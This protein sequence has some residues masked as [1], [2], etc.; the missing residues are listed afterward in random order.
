MYYFTCA[1]SFFFC[2][3]FFFSNVRNLQINTVAALTCFIHGCFYLQS[4]RC[5]GRATKKIPPWF[6]GQGPAASMLVGGGQ[7][8]TRR[9]EG[10][11]SKLEHFFKLMYDKFTI[12]H[13]F[14]HHY[15]RKHG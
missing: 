9:M 10:D 15:Q 7:G 14:R 13:H 12:L 8:R 2:S 1:Q 4:N 11:Q 5:V 3:T 6:G